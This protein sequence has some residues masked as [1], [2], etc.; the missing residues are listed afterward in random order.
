VSFTSKKFGEEG[1]QLAL[2]LLREK[3]YEII[4][5]NYRFGKGEID[6]IA[7]D[8]ETKYTVFVEVKTRN[9]LEYGEPEYA[10]TLNKIKQLRRMAQAYLFDKDI[11][12]RDCRFDVIAILFRQKEKPLI[13]HYI[14]AF[15]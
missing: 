14:N 2:E 4:E 8:P 3:G 7:L 12:E 13:N 1:E 5:K 11:R 6:I 15:N 10:I 9:N